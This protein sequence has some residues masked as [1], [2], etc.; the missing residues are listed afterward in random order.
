MIIYKITNKINN[1]VYIGQT[2]RS[3]KKRWIEHC[4]KGSCCPFIHR[5]IAK[6]GV[7]NFTIEQI[8]HSHSREELDNKEV[9]WIE[10]YNSI[11][12]NGYN[13][14]SGGETNKN[15]NEEVRRKISDGHKGEKNHRFGTHIS[16]EHKQK[17]SEANKGIKWSKERRLK[18]TGSKHPRAR[19]VICVETGEVFDCIK[20]ASENKKLNHRNISNVCLGKRKTCG[21][22][23]WRYVDE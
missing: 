18:I 8:D 10:F 6:Y 13:L 2:I 15:I 19:A 3:L 7:D 20:S 1:K 21:N 11:A 4:C 14:T 17:I 5:A 12:P 9:F 23:H 22:F 16:E